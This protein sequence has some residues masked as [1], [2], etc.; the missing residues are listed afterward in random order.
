MAMWGVALDQGYGDKTVRQEALAAVS[1]ESLSTGSQ[2]RHSSHA[3]LVKLFFFFFLE[4]LTHILVV[5]EELKTRMLFLD[6][7]KPSDRG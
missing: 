5:L 1:Q 4:G 7:G 6:L 3:M 2:N